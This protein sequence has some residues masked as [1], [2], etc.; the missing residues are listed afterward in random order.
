[1]LHYVGE[2]IK[3]KGLEMV[4][5]VRVYIV[6]KRFFIRKGVWEGER[7]LFTFGMREMTGRV[8]GQK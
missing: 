4:N 3:S 1:M 5:I 8:R 2:S 7:K 6:D